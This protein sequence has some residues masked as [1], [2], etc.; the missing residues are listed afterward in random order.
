MTDRERGNTKGDA[1]TLKEEDRERKTMRSAT[2][3]RGGEEE[4][5]TWRLSRALLTAVNTSIDNLSMYNERGEREG[6]KEG[7]REGGR[8]AVRERGRE[9]EQRERERAGERADRPWRAS[10]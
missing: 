8:E 5:E 9:G 6:E 1:K 3:R 2:G 4:T 10:R 7:G